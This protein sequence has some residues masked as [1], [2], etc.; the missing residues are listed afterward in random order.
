M[1]ATFM[2]RLMSK[3]G[4]YAFF[5]IAGI[6][7]VTILI[8]FTATLQKEVP[9]IAKTVKSSS[10]EVLYTYDDVVEGKGYFQEFDLMDYGTLLGMGAYLGPDFTTEFLHKRAE[11]LYEAYAKELYG[12]SVSELNAIELAGVKA[13][14]IQDVKEQTS[15]REDG[16]IYTEASAAAY[17]QNVA[18]IVD[19]LV[20]GNKEHAW[21]AGVI[22]EDEAKKIAAFLTGHN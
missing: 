16:V 22:H 12:K 13:R 15:L 7:M 6:F 20:N 3:K 18:Y 5:W 2:E 10:G 19:F 1:N 14:T 17:K 8:Y 11:F 4:L 21:R 9:P